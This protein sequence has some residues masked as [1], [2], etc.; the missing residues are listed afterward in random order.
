MYH[1]PEISSRGL[2]DFHFKY[3]TVG[4]YFLQSEK[5]TDPDR[6]D[7]RKENFG[8][9][10]REYET[11]SGNEGGKKGHWRRFERYVRHVNEKS[12]LGVQF[13]VLFL[14]RHGQGWHNVAEA[15]Y[16][17]AAWNCYWSMLD[18][19]DG[20]TWSDAH[21]TEIGHA[22]AQDVRQLWQ[23]LLPDIPAPESYYVS[24]LTRAI[25]TAD[26]SFKGLELPN[27]KP[28]KPIIK[29]LLREAI[30]VHTCD[31]RRSASEIQHAFPHVSLES[32]FSEE[33]PLWT[34]NFRE[35]RKAR[36]HR[37][38]KLLD[39]VFAH[40]DGVFLSFTSHS[41]AIRSILDAIGHRE[42]GLETGGVIPVF[43][44]AEVVKGARPAP[45]DEP[46]EGPPACPSPPVMMPN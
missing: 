2:Q 30:G 16:G 11:D 13:K 6:F 1:V 4:G 21:L 42:F 33:D 46:S 23:S 3:T 24:P 15:K 27:G 10:D 8:L 40:D 5:D 25:E 45:P 41:G 28:Y 38:A 36:K 14:G 22:Q 19:A 34:S 44:K 26:I 31:R 17:T 20:I 12:E 7:F 18:G 37:L 9:I 29:E 32:G 43:V 35:P 39:D